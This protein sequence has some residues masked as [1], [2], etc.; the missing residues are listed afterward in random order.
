MAPVKRAATSLRRAPLPALPGRQ[1]QGDT[2]R[3][4]R[5]AAAS[6]SKRPTSFSLASGQINLSASGASRARLSL[7][8]NHWLVR[9][10]RTDFWIRRQNSFIFFFLA[11]SLCDRFG[12]PR[13]G[14]SPMC[15]SLVKALPASD[16][17]LNCDHPRR[18]RRRRRHRN[19]ANPLTTTCT[20]VLIRHGERV[21]NSVAT[22]TK[23]RGAQNP[24][25]V[26]PV[27]THRARRLRH[28]LARDGRGA[29][30]LGRQGALFDQLS[31]A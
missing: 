28:R 4:P 16:A 9:S 30:A 24:H 10:T 11:R 6:Q 22:M 15:R 26:S 5:R 2:R 20:G 3:R 7:E 1:L 13:V 23:A 17:R 18:R 12:L 31:S 21:S 14:P 8:V 25:P 27:R 29:E 19:L